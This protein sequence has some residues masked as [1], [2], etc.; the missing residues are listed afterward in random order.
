MAVIDDKVVAMSFEH[1]KFEQGVSKTISLLDKLKAALRFPEAGKGLEEFDKAAKKVDLSHIGTAVDNIQNK[2][3]YLSVAALAIFAD[4]ARHAV[5]SATRMIKAFTL[6]PLIAGFQEYST[7]LN[8]IQTILANTQASGADL[9]DVNAALQEL[10]EYSDKTIYNF[11]QMARNIGTFTAA[12]VALEPATA[13]IK[14]IANLAALSGSNS[15]QAASAMYQLSQA[16]SS[17]RVSLMDWNSVV[18]AGM[19]GTVFQRALAQTAVAMGEL[20]ESSL[21]LVG[22]MKNVSINGESFRQ[23]MQAGPGKQSWLTS[24]VLTKTLQQFTGDLSAAELAAQG[25]NEEQIKS[26][27]ATALTAQKAATEVKT[28]KQVF[29][30][31]KETAGSGWA[32]TFQIIFGNFEEAKETFTALSN[33]INGFIN[34]NADARN[35]VLK[36]WKA[37]GGRTLLINSIK[38]A[39]EALG[40]ILKPIRQAFR[41]FFPAKTGRDLVAFTTKIWELSEA[42][43]PSQETIDNIRRTF[44]GL[45]AILDIG[46]MIIGGIFTVFRKMFGAVSEGEGSF[47]NFT[48][49]IGDFLVSLDKAL[50]KGDRLNKFFE[51]LGSILAAPIQLI[52][53]LAEVIGDLFSKFS[54]GDFSDKADSIGQSLSPLQVIMEAIA[55]AWQ[56]FLQGFDNADQVVQTVVDAIVK[57]FEQLGPSIAKVFSNLNFDAILAVIRTGLFAGLVVMFKQFLGRGSFI[58]QLFGPRSILSNVSGIFGPLT[59]SLKSLQTNIRAKTLKELAIAIALLAVSV[60]ALS[61]VSP[62]KLKASLTAMTVMFGQLIG[63]MAVIEK[64]STTGGFIKLPV[65]IASLTGL[66][67][68][69][70]LLTIA[71]LALSQLDNDE[72]IRGLGGVTAMLGGLTAVAGPLG[73]SSA[74]LIRAGV[75]IT[76]IAVGLNILALAVRQFGEM[77]LSTLAKGLG[78]VG[79]GLAAIALGMKFMPTG[80]VL[81]GAAL[82]AIATSLNILADAVLRFGVLRW[83][84]IGKGLAGVGGG[85]AIIAGAMHLMPSNMVLTAAG[86]ILVSLAL[87]KIVDAVAKMGKMSVKQIATGLAGLGGALGILAAGLYLMSGSLAGA[88]A[89]GVAAA[90][91]ALLTPSLIALGKQSWKTIITGLVSMGAALGVLVGAAALAGTV[92]PLLLGFGAALTLIGA[93]MLLAGAGIALV[94]VGLSAIAVAGPTAL[95]IL[96]AAWR[97][98]VDFIPEF[99][100]DVVLG[101][102]TMVEAFAK[103]APQFVDA[104]IKII[105]AL[106]DAIVRLTPKIAKAFQVLLNAALKIFYN[107]KDE[108]IQAG[109]D[110]IVSLLEGIDNNIG[111]LL[112]VAGD[113]VVSFISGLATQ[114]NKIVQAGVKFIAKFIDGIVDGMLDLVD[115]GARAVLKF[116]NGIADA[117]EKYEPQIIVAGGRIGIALV[118]GFIKGMWGLK[119]K[120]IQKAEELF[121]S[122]P[123]WVRK[124]FKITSPSLVFQDIGEQ[125]VWGFVKGVEKVTPK[126]EEAAEEMANNTTKKVKQAAKETFEILEGITRGAIAN[127]GRGIRG[128]L[129]DI[130]SAFGEL[131]RELTSIAKNARETIKTE[132]ERLDELLKHPLKNA[133]NIKRARRA[134]AENQ[135]ILDE[136]RTGHLLLTKALLDERMT[137]QSLARSYDMINAKLEAANQALADAKQLRDDAFKQYRDQFSQLPDMLTKDADGRPIED[138]VEKYKTAIKNQIQAVKDYQKTLRQLRKLGLDD[139]TYKALLEQGTAGQDFADQLLAGGKDSIKQVNK[140]DADLLKASAGLATDASKGLYQAGVDAAQGLVDGLKSVKKELSKAMADVALS[141]VTAVKKALK[142]KS[143]SE[144]FADIGKEVTRGFAKGLLDSSKAVTDAIYMVSDDAMGAMQQTFNKMSDIV[145]DEI[146]PNPTITPILDL[147][148]VRTGAQALGSIFGTTPIA[149]TVSTSQAAAISARQTSVETDEPIVATGGTAIKFEQ[150]NYS[151]KALDPIDVYRAT[152]SQLA[153]LRS[154]VVPEGG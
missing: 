43:K 2:L 97:E 125:V 134:I 99:V 137:L 105:G 18:N 148:Q 82:I 115:A 75:G 26:I 49:N 150:N 23:S 79:G 74:G 92:T 57:I 25:F 154:V 65:I 149:A 123:G 89:L 91:I 151:P 121:E 129:S 38:N 15:E 6:D 40:E 9:E 8:S 16:I 21:K 106:L 100:Q 51:R 54:P 86:L 114:A 30:V 153:Q 94:G 140:L 142:I 20:K 1:Q 102:L 122:L 76:A 147:T 77:N 45:F 146:N 126:A 33:T 83:Q 53:R 85:L 56:K 39:F 64:L 55:D 70:D 62:E 67:I 13:A 46:K 128:G 120:L 5:A 107:N 31:A 124:I 144:V 4:I 111:A 24:D 141:I 130:K 52:R 27:Q 116:L 14:G 95:G 48:G 93:G 87:E 133:D 98:F 71:V 117:I 118:E 81:Q 90:G 19:G 78:A 112:D 28:I 3:G 84:V 152:R 7:N 136:S 135:R 103:T 35:K 12:G 37:L 10:N 131:D 58:E 80:M 69:I 47:L 66:A 145:T 143:P 42:L 127:F 41:E 63:A 11:S 68:A 104:L 17:G 138:A 113:V 59:G 88:A 109:F 32:Q 108:L 44:R 73:K 29:D 72:L 61:L 139:T 119:D 50:K 101:L 60:L 36:D 110:L 22:P 132:Q 96:L 34:T